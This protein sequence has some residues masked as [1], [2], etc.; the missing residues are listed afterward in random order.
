M[1]PESVQRHLSS[2]DR[3]NICKNMIPIGSR[4]NNKDAPSVGSWNVW[5]G[6]VH[7]ANAHNGVLAPI[8]GASGPPSFYADENEGA[9]NSGYDT[10]HKSFRS[11]CRIITGQQL[12]G[13]AAVAIYK[14]LLSIMGSSLDNPY[15]LTPESILAIA[16]MDCG[17]NHVIEE[18]L[19][20]PAGLSNAKIR[21]IIDLSRHYKCGNLSDSFLFD[22]QITID[23]LRDKLCQVK[24][25]GPWSC[26]MFLIFHAH[27][28]DILPLG[29]LAVRK[30]TA[31][32][33]GVKGS[34][35]NGA[36]CEKKDLAMLTRI[37]EPFAPYRSLSTYY[38]WRCADTK[39][40]N[41]S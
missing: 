28:P 6:L 24:G 33:F 26:D 14:R 19:R 31:K 11:L 17:E 37:H 21:S 18:K 35:K 34:G 23:V 41:A 36:L 7:V 22:N 16:D 3:D 15:G 29:D 39:A 9:T 5:D 13:S 30:G 32:L 2:L 8:I 27:K 20:K 1:K 25:L 4:H 10:D 12:A 40:F 38:M